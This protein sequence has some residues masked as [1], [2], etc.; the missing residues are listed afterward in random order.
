MNKYKCLKG[1]TAL[2][3]V[4]FMPLHMAAADDSLA[5]FLGS[6]RLELH[7]VFK[8]QR[9]PN[10][11]VAKDGSV[12]ASWGSQGIQVRRSIDGGAT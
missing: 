8:D 3:V 9:F 1:M 5:S 10:L 6:P 11:T 2:F 12:L 7:Q 4:A